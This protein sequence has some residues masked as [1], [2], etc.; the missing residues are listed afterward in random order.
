MF[1]NTTYEEWV[2]VVTPKVAGTWNLHKA[3]EGHE[4]DFFVLFSSTSGVVGYKGQANYAAGSVFQDAF[5]QTRQ[6]QGLPASVIDVG[7]VEDI[8]YVAQ[9][10][11][12]RARLRQSLLA[13]TT[14]RGVLNALEL[15]IKKSS[16]AAGSSDALTAGGG[17]YASGSQFCVGFGTTVPL[18]HPNNHVSW[19]RDPRCAIYRNIN[20]GN[21]LLTGGGDGSGNDGDTNAKFR[22]FIAAAEAQPGSI[23]QEDKTGELAHLVG[24]TLCGFMMRPADD[25]DV[26]AGIATLGIDSLVAIELKNWFSQRLAMDVSVLEI[27]NAHSLLGLAGMVAERLTAKWGGVEA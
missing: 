13:F 8:G 18:M 11:Q 21:E 17:S 6:K 2:D 19:K 24:A 25:V 26:K 4:L 3:L 16:P 9:N 10:P 27:M 15:A 23:L 7:P 12:V 1:E 22:A 14:E 5:V 20:G